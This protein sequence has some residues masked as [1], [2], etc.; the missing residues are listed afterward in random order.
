MAR[1]KRILPPI[2]TKLKGKFMGREYSAEAVEAPHL[3]KGG[4][5]HT[6]ARYSAQ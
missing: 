6:K 4:V 1:S 2:G 5:F 3:K